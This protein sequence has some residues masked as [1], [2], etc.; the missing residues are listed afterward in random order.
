[1]RIVSDPDSLA[2]NRRRCRLSRSRGCPCV[3]DICVSV[4]ALHVGV[5]S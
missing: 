2:V 1:M 5:G 3:L 4:F